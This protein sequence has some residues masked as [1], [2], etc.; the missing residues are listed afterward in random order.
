MLGALLTTSL[1]LSQPVQTADA[2]ITIPGR[3]PIDQAIVS[4]D[5]RRLFLA[6][7]AGA[8]AFDLDTGKLLFNGASGRVIECS[9]KGDLLAVLQINVG[10]TSVGGTVSVLDTATGKLLHQSP[11]TAAAFSPDSRWLISSS[12][13]GVGRPERDEPPKVQITDLRTGKMHLA[14]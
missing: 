7:Q 6:T 2:T 13:Y 5:G 4:P 11:G 3:A 9:P 12:S 10:M 1:F 14:Q 8:E